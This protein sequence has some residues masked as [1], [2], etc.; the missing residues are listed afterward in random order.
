MAK[1]PT[2]QKGKAEYQVSTAI[3]DLLLAAQESGDDSLET[4]RYLITYKE[5]AVDEGLQYLKAQGLKT[6]DARDFKIKVSS[7][8]MSATPRQW[9]FRRLV[10]HLWA[11]RR[12]SSAA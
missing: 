9:F 4:G 7:C 8:R 10:W 6:T 12:S 5:N 1:R 11:E 2:S 3:D